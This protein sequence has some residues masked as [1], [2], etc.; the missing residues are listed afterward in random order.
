MDIV[1]PDLTNAFGRWGRYLV[2]AEL[3]ALVLDAR[4][5]RAASREKTWPGKLFTLG[6]GICQE[7]WTYR[8]TA[9]G[10]ATLAFQG[11][12]AKDAAP[13]TRHLPLTF[14]AGVPEPAPKRSRT[15]G[16]KKRSGGCS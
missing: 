12:H 6:A 11:S 2:D 3:T 15:P 13:P 4:A 1:V 10:T 14:T 7:S 5:E 16:A 8:A 9:K